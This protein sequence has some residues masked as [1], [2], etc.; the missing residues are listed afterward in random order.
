MTPSDE[1]PDRPTN[2][3][4]LSFSALEEQD[5]LVQAFRDFVYSELSKPE[6]NNISEVIAEF[7]RRVNF[8]TKYFGIDQLTDDLASQIPKLSD[9]KMA[10]LALDGV[11]SDEG[12]SRLAHYL[13][14][15]PYPHYETDPTNRDLVVRIEENGSRVVGHFVDENFVAINDEQ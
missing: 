11:D 14:A 7:S 4:E 5:A 9:A 2:N 10:K 15:L 6:Q 1:L 12:R 3:S 8:L 13:Q